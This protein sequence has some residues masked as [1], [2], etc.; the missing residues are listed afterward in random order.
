MQILSRINWVDVFVLILMVRMS[1]VAFMDGANMNGAT[2][3]RYDGTVWVAVG[4]PGFSPGQAL[5][6]SLAFGATDDPYVA[7]GDVANGVRATVMAG[8]W[9]GGSPGASGDSFSFS[10][11]SRIS[12]PASAFS[13]AI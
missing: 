1:Y 2:V 10:F 7:F 13:L 4:Q 8:G 6:V 11:S 9:P 12:T 5:D 3:M